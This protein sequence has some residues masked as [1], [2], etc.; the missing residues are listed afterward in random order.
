M[1]KAT[2]QEAVRFLK[3]LGWK[4]GFGGLVAPMDSAYRD[5]ASEVSDNA[6]FRHPLDSV[7]KKSPGDV[8]VYSVN[9]ILATIEGILNYGADRHEAALAL[10]NSK[11]IPE[12]QKGSVPHANMGHHIAALNIAAIMEDIFRPQ[13]ALEWATKH[14]KEE[15]PE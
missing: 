5:M 15:Y 4:Q 7:E 1:K 6:P 11:L 9:A 8:P 2:E 14:L 13:E 12:D 3:T 10:R